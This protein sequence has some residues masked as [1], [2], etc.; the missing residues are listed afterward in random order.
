MKKM[1]K[2]LAMLLAAVMV[3]GM[4]V[5]ALAD[6]PKPDPNANTSI[7]ITG[8]PKETDSVTV[9]INGLT[10]AE[11]D[12]EESVT[13]D[14]YRIA[15]AYY[16]ESDKVGFIK[17]IWDYNFVFPEDEQTGAPEF[18]TKKDEKVDTT[19]FYKEENGKVETSAMLTANIVRIANALVKDGATPVEDGIKTN[20]KTTCTF[21][22][23]A[24]IYIAIITASANG[25]VY[26][27]VLL[28][29]TYNKTENGAALVG[30]TINVAEAHYLNGSD[31]VAKRSTPRIEKN[32]TGG[33]QKE[34]VTVTNNVPK[35]TIREEEKDKIHTA[36]VGDVIN[37]SVTPTMPSYPA[38]AVNRTLIISDQ[39]EKG[40][41]LKPET[42]KITLDSKTYEL[43]EEAKQNPSTYKF[44]KGDSKATFATVTFTKSV[45]TLTSYDG[46]YISFVYNEL[47]IPNSPTETV[48]V[49][50][51]TYDAILNEDAVEGSVGNTNTAKL[52]Y[53]NKPNTGST[54]ETLPGSPEDEI[55]WG[56]KHKEDEETVYTYQL[57]FRK[58]DDNEEKPAYLDGAVF[59]IY[60]EEACTNLVGQVT[61]NETGYAVFAN[62][63]AGTY[64]LK[65]LIAPAGYSLLEG[66]T[67]IIASWTGATTT[68]SK[69]TITQIRYTTVKPSDDAEQVGWIK[70]GVFYEMGTWTEE[71]AE[72]DN[73]KVAYRASGYENVTPTTTTT[74][75]VTDISEGSAG[76]GTVLL[77][78]PIKNTKLASLP[79]T[80]GIGTTIFTIGGCAIMIIAAGLFFATRRKAEK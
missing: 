40:L 61:T 15:H 45:D 4:S 39:M 23:G 46:F 2:L 79:S 51:V 49:P 33:T 76:A 47:L 53:S 24:G 41:T 50:T 68:I 78:S 72:K 65:E 62:V 80:G 25:Y 54:H 66:T 52:T 16:D 8:E 26:N 3:M 1:K 31:A 71:T 30:G 22:V 28:T 7:R 57:A 37:Y 74:I 19:L 34:E 32:I 48:Y 77:Q 60:K 35:N 64:Y 18:S 14:L 73:A 9:K 5:T 55:A 13:V 21:E 36:T 43:S 27:P 6:E 58:S 67:P 75:S 44:Q 63:E 69:E 70:N 10:A 38:D 11:G 29:A 20:Q 12:G 42:L 56:L 59:G 17:Y